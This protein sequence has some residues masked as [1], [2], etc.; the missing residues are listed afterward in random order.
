[1]KKSFIAICMIG[2][3]LVVF[4]NCSDK[5][6]SSR[7][8]LNK[9]L[10]SLD[11]SEQLVEDDV[12]VQIEDDVN[13]VVNNDDDKQHGGMNGGS[14]T[15]GST[16]AMSSG[17]DDDDDHHGHSG[18]GSSSGGST[19]A[20]SSGDDDDKDE[21]AE[22]DDD[23]KKEEHTNQGKDEHKG[24]KCH[25]KKDGNGRFVC[26][27]PGAGKSRH[28]AVINEQI[29]SE[30]STPKTACMSRDA[31]EKIVGG[32]LDV[33]SVESR[34]YCKNETKQVL[35]FTDAEVKELVDK[36]K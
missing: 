36:I 6:F 31:C 34:G 11:G 24:N 27:L 1:M 5:Q 33:K 29:V 16:T 4:Q 2:A 28:V 35:V 17:D 30:N 19:S 23:D 20:S 10:S 32:K 7:T 15:G 22:N 8:D 12:P 9:T 18:G 21:V 3:M 14:G 13:E 25:D 26:I